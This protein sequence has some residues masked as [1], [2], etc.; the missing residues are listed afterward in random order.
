MPHVYEPA[1]RLVR[2]E[3]WKGSVGRFGEEE[4]ELPDGRR[5]TLGVLQHPGAC[6]VVPLLPDGRVVML[7]QYRYAV[8][9]TLW[10]VP[11]G[12]LDPGEGLEACA[13]RELE[14]ETGYVAGE[15]I[16]LGSIYPTPGFCD[17]RIHLYV[18]RDLRPGT[19]AH[20]ATESLQ[21]EPM[22]FE[23]AVAMAESGEITD[24]KTVIALLRARRHCTG[25]PGAVGPPC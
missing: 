12:K 5:F 3:L 8:G 11:A 18:A 21:P 19:Q 24:A 9:E 7:R 22:R 25:A 10:E 4:I 20:D 14:E 6:A 15:L 17:E 2:R 23:A 16:S 13:R 1:R